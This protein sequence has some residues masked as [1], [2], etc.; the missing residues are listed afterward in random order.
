ML[1]G[2]RRACPSDGSRASRLLEHATFPS[3]FRL[4]VGSTTQRYHA[5]PL[6]SVS[7]IVQAA[8]RRTGLGDD[9]RLEAAHGAACG[10]LPVRVV[11]GGGLALQPIAG[12]DGPPGG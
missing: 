4:Q 6:P 12:G 1:S 9:A 10:T 3:G 7:G 5:Q 11:L 2:S 8:M